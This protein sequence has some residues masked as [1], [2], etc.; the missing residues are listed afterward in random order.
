MTVRD[1]SLGLIYIAVFCLQ[2]VMFYLSSMA[3][4]PVPVPVLL[5]QP[6]DEELPEDI[7]TVHEH[8]Y[9]AS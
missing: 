4:N 6:D 9:L 5:Q 2:S 8:I 7:D 3:L 1:F